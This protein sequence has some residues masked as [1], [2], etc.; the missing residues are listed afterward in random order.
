M[1]FAYLLPLSVPM[2]THCTPIEVLQGLPLPSLTQPDKRV[3]HVNQARLSS[4]DP[5]FLVSSINFFFYLIRYLEHTFS[6][7]PSRPPSDVLW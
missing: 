7:A 6:S 3:Q 1:R 2:I 5:R 4:K